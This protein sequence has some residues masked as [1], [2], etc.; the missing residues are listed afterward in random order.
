MPFG[1][2]YGGQQAKRRGPLMNAARASTGR[3][4]G[5]P[6]LGGPPASP[7]GGADQFPPVP[8]QRSVLRR[9]P[10]PGATGPMPFGPLA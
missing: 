1:I 6:P 3:S 2:G 8:R 9:M 7:G 5:G 10:R 4:L